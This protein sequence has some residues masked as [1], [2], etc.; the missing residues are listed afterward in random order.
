VAFVLSWQK[1]LLL[2]AVVKQLVLQSHQQM[3]LSNSSLA[4]KLLTYHS[5]TY[6]GALNG[7]HICRP[8]DGKHKVTQLYC[9]CSQM[10]ELS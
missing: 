10:A 7:L 3:H 5:A 1:Y 4:C 9:Y 6:W 2:V 8:D